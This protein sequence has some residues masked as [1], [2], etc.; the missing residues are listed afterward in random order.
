MC[1]TTIDPQIFMTDLSALSPSQL[2][3]SAEKLA[4]VRS[5]FDGS[6]DSMDPIPVK[7]LAGRLLM[8]DGHTRAAAAYLSGLGS[9]PCVWDQDNM[10]WAAYAA[11]INMCAEEGITSV[12]ALAKRIVS[13][14]DYK[15]LW[16][17]RCDA[18]YNERYYK[19][20]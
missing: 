7:K 15:T 8:T 10:D 4:K 9:V 3:V 5:W 12:G 14:A 17:D 16:H 19:V 1:R 6:T 18:M 11:D 2:C 13:P 20:L